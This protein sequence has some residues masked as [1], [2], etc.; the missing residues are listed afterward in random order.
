MMKRYINGNVSIVI[1]I[2]YSTI[3]VVKKVCKI[4]QTDLE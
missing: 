1:I 4:F 2:P 3:S